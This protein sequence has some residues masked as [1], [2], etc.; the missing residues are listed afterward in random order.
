MASLGRNV[1]IV[2]D[3]GSGAA[4]Q[5][6]ITWAKVHPVLC[7]HMSSLGHNGLIVSDNVRQQAITRANVDRVICRY[8]ASLDHNELC[9]TM[10]LELSDNKPL[11][12]PMLTQFYFALWRH[13][14]TLN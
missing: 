13:Y 14:F 1:L 3:N 6:A 7:P 8:M 5:Q 10:G 4:R 9:L 2:S 12:E 11:P